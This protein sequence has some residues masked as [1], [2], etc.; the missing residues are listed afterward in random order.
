M[1]R[2][3]SAPLKI[4][5]RLDE[6]GY[7][8]DTPVV[9]RTG[10]LTYRN[11]DGTLRN[12]LR[13]DE[14]V[15]DPE[16]LASFAGVP[17]TIKHPAMLNAKNYKKF[18]VGTVLGIGER[19]DD[20]NLAVPIIIHDAAAVEMA[21]SRKL[22]EL[23]VA[24]DVEFVERPGWYNTK[25]RDVKYDDEGNLQNPESMGYTR[26]DGLQTRV[27]ANAIGMVQRGR[28]GRV[29]RLNLDGDEEFSVADFE[30]PEGGKMQKVRLDNGLEYEAAPE[31][32][33]ALDKLRADAADTKQ[34]VESLTADVGTLTGE[35][36]TL[37]TTVAGFADK[38]AQIRKDA[39]DSIRAELTERVELEG[40]ATK[41]GV[42]FD[43]LDNLEVKKAVYKAVTK[44][45]LDSED[46]AYINGA[47]KTAVSMMG[48][49]SQR[50]ALNTP[51]N[52][53]SDADDG[54]GSQHDARQ[55]MID[56]QHG[57]KA[58]TK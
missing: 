13:L 48:I 1:L 12:E 3:D 10:I 45:N 55:K 7:L 32:V 2:Y 56:R 29:A 52:Q 34:K 50:R 6:Q 57:K 58:G 4:K 11:A 37:K 51:V 22:T 21:Q 39:E 35:R 54:T 49:Q 43:G 33:I 15:F 23:S 41:A 8:R 14:H 25:T 36:D 24:Y 5:A 47:F 42:K 16:S 31:V 30:N 40:F 28:A 26:F 9:A 44:Q 46:G 53:R 38:E 20:D 27:K 17:I 19:K 18:A